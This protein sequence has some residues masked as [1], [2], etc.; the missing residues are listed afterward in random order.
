MDHACSCTVVL[1]FTLAFLP[2]VKSEVST[3]I[4][5]TLNYKSY[6]RNIKINGQNNSL[7]IFVPKISFGCITEPSVSMKALL[8]VSTISP[9]EVKIQGVKSKLYL[10][11]D[12]NG[13]LYGEVDVNEEGTIF[14]ASL[15]GYYNTYLSRKYAHLGW[16]VGIKKSGKPKRGSKTKWGQK[17][18]QFLPRRLEL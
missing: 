2:M 17:A 18:I 10:A 1:A 12:R 6:N 8:E 15:L 9:D 14:V 13:R 16:Y 7:C 11:M 4:W 5:M 3:E